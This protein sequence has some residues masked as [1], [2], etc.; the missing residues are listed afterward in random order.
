MRNAYLAELIKK[1]EDL[2]G[3]AEKTFGGLNSRQLNWKPG[4]K[5]WS[6]GQCFDHLMTSNKTYFP[7]LEKISRGEKKN[8]PWESMP[9]FP[10]LF[11][12]MVIKAVD[13]ASQKKYKTFPVFEPSNSAIPESIIGDFSK[14][15]KELLE[16]LRRTD[17]A[18][19]QRV[20]ITSPA[21]QIITYS[22]H[23]CCTLL[24]THEERHFLQAKRVLE[25]DAFPRS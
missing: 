4:E 5:R 19:H 8:S 22:L 6:I 14:H 21:S 16:L 1:G 15:Q 25:M 13:P 18:D 23:D 11:G 3:K 9:L 7:V 17:A 10:V 24:I 20:K 12:K 2:A